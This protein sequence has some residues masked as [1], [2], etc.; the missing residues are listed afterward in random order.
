MVAEPESAKAR[1]VKIPRSANIDETHS[2]PETRQR[3]S[4]ESL[5]IVMGKAFVSVRL[6][7]MLIVVSTPLP[8]AKSA[9]VR[10]AWLKVKVAVLGPATG[11]P[12]QVALT[13]T[14]P[15]R[16]G[17]TVVWLPTVLA[18]KLNTGF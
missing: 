11:G 3:L 16:R 17:V 1:T 2:L 4:G 14:S 5:V 7:W 10:A 13:V 18:K 9:S 12:E 6:D 8:A 15:A